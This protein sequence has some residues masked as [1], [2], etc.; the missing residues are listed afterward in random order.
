MKA[1]RSSKWRLVEIAT[2]AIDAG[3]EVTVLIAGDPHWRRVSSIS[4]AEGHLDLI[5]LTVFNLHQREGSGALLV[6]DV[7]SL[8]AVLIADD[9]AD[10]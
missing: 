1:E 8:T 2:E 5:Q 4:S 9:D 10:I 6:M 7:E 3:S